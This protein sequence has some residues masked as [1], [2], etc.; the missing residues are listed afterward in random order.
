MNRTVRRGRKKCLAERVLCAGFD[1]KCIRRKFALVN[2]PNCGIRLVPDEKPLPVPEGYG[3][4]T[5]RLHQGGPM[6]QV[7]TTHH[8]QKGW[9]EI[10]RFTKEEAEEEWRRTFGERK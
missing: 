6:W 9:I 4:I 8:S 1:S 5:S 7:L 3:D 10:V 2:C